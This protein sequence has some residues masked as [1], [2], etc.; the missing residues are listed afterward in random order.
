MIF[1]LESE[2]IADKSWNLKLFLPYKDL[3]ESQDVLEDALAY[4]AVSF[5]NVGKNRGNFFEDEGRDLWVA[6]A[7]KLNKILDQIKQFRFVL[8][9][10]FADQMIQPW[11]L[12]E[13]VAF[14]CHFN[15]SFCSCKYPFE[16]SLR[17][18]CFKERDQFAWQTWHTF[19]VLFNNSSD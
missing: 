15:A 10:C 4:F 9:K 7:I 17:Q 8:F 18:F 13:V 12:L 16:D 11:R 6:V 3:S 5:I 1:D 14:W 19:I 2:E